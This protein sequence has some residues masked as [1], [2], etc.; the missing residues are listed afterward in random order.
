MSNFVPPAVPPHDS[1]AFHGED[2]PTKDVDGD[3]VL[4]PDANDD[5][6]DSAEADRIAADGDDDALERN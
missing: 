4:D 5:L 1:D 2:A 6:V 3:T